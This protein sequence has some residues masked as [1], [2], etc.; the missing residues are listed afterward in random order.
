MCYKVECNDKTKQLVVYVGDS[1][2]ICPTNGG[3]TVGSGYKGILTCPK[4]YDICGTQTAQLCNDIFDC[5]NKKLLVDEKSYDFPSG[6]NNFD[7]YVYSGSSS[8]IKF[9][10][11]YLL[12]NIALLLLI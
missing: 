7:R 9:S 2:F 6:T 3:I 12:I 1:T 5:L 8:N 4:Y 11:H 10:F